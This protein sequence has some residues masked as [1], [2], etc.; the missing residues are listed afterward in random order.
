MFH[1][2]DGETDVCRSGLGWGCW[3]I[4]QY[5]CDEESIIV[6]GGL[7]S[8]C[9]A[10]DVGELN[11]STDQPC[12]RAL[13]TSVRLPLP[14]YDCSTLIHLSAYLLKFWMLKGQKAMIFSL[15]NLFLGLF[16]LCRMFR[17]GI[18]GSWDKCEFFR[19]LLGRP[20]VRISVRTSPVLCKCLSFLLPAIQILGCYF[21]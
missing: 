14:N 5:C 12:S 11:N 4:W 6:T 17:E 16:A 3:P 9:S 7:V 1:Q 19:S 21:D 15:V 8:L 18:W 13:L 2:E 20:P 10:F